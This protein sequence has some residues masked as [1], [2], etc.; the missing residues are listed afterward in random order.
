MARVA[1]ARRVKRVNTNTYPDDPNVPVGTNEW[2]ADPESSGLLGF[3]KISATLD[4]SGVLSTKDDSATFTNES[5]S[6]QAKQSTLIEVECNGSS[7]TDAVEKISITDTNENDIVYLFKGTNG[8]TV[9]VTHTGSLSSNGQIQSLDGN[10]I[11]INDT[12]K[13]VCL[14]R[15]GNY[16]FE[17]GGGG[18]VN[19]LNDV[20][21]VTISGI[22]N[23]ELLKWNGSAFVNN[24]ISEAGLASASHNHNTSDIN[25]GTL[26]HER[27]GL[28]ADVS[29]F[30]GL[31]KVSGGSTSAITDTISGVTAGTVSASKALVVDSNKDLTG[32]N[33]VTI[34]GDLT[35]NGTTTTINSTTL[36]VDD[37]NIEI[38]SVGSPSDTTAD[39]GGITLK[40][41]T[42]KTILW[43]NSTDSWDFN[44]TVDI[45]AQKELRFSDSDSSNYVAFKSPATVSSNVSWILPNAD[46]SADTFLKTDG[47]GNLT[48]D[49]AGGGA[50]DQQFWIDASA[51]IPVPSST[52]G[53]WTSYS[54]QRSQSN[55]VAISSVCYPYTAGTTS[56]SRAVVNWVPPKNWNNGTIKVKI[57]ATFQDGSST[58]TGNFT[59]KVS[60][61]AISNDDSMNASFGTAVSVTDACSVA[62][63]LHISPIS[64]AITVGG[65]PADADFVQIK[66]ARVDS[67][68]N[69]MNAGSVVEFL[70]MV[71]QY[72]QDA[73]TSSD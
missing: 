27:G 3:T 24:T 70:G 7:T 10:S 30:N 4:A 25:A 54:H 50:G 55:G 28:E 36:S 5:G 31:V 43:T 68:S 38:G 20:G 46:G 47:S 48:W 22:A 26:V 44:Q 37:K 32:L 2:N 19:A 67:S 39:G 6:A 63:D 1:Y 34:A 18:S 12:A 62:N 8:D 14:I 59:F 35:V 21:D 72:T 41:A 13:P 9:T 64:G 57:Y 73:T 58:F 15:R 11:T 56:E 49:T 16:W 60:A 17:F 52:S 23:G 29:S 65:S 71:V 40:G 66:V 33:D 51:F 53:N 42:D 45:K 69:P 61:V